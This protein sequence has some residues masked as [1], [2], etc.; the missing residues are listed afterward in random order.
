M[1]HFGTTV[2]SGDTGTVLGVARGSGKLVR[3]EYLRRRA[4][5]FAARPDLDI[6][7]TRGDGY[8]R[9]G[10]PRYLEDAWGHPTYAQIF[11]NINPIWEVTPSVSYSFNSYCKLT[12]EVMLHVQ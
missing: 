12:A 4:D 1:G 2:Q 11:S 9:F 10:V 8:P 6:G 3:V 5:S 7:G